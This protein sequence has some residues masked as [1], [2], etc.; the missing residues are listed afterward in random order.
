MERIKQ[1]EYE[2]RGNTRFTYEAGLKRMFAACHKPVPAE[3]ENL[4]HRL[5]KLDDESGNKNSR[6][7]P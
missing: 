5:E 1:N 4:L 6:G 3:M 2:A 7:C